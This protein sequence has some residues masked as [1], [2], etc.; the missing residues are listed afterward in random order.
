MNALIIMAKISLVTLFL[1]SLI[2][3]ILFQSL[4]ASEHN[5][6]LKGASNSTSNA[7]ATAA[8]RTSA[9][10]PLHQVKLPDF[11][12]IRDVKDKKRQFFNFIKP[13]VERENEAVLSDRELLI[14]LRDKLSQNLVLSV[15]ENQFLS[16]L[17]KKYEVDFEAS[18]SAVVAEL[19]I[20]VDIIPQGI[21]LVQAANE[22][23]WGTSRFARIGLNF[24]G[25]WCYRPTCGMVPSGR[26]TGAKHEV[27]AFQSVDAAVKRYLL[28]INTHYAY[29]ALRDKR[30]ALRTAGGPLLANELV[31]GL[32]SYS[33][34][35]QAYIDEI[36]AMLKYNQRYF[37]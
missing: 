12:K 27:A 20:R 7:K 1:V 9:E 26:N 35:G 11:S 31:S 18:I 3:P 23:A 8:I 34:R 25:I 37:Y 29:K 15:Q 36:S 5:N 19:V 32:M 17:A 28:N 13:S 14:S 4:I 21:V 30:A 2:V 22:S 16:G 6:S 24:F 10:K 33:E